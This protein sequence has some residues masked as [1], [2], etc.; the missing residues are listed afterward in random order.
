MGVIQ[1]GKKVSTPT[2]TNVT[3]FKFEEVAQEKK[4]LTRGRCAFN[5]LLTL[6]CV[7]SPPLPGH[8][9]VD[10]RGWSVFV[11]MINRE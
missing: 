7:I 2:Q 9:F 1:Q 4:E 3:S 6:T 11:L 10:L 8:V 5:C